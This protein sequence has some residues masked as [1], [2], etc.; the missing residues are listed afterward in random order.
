MIFSPVRSPIRSAIGS[1]VGLLKTSALVFPLDQAGAM[2]AAAYGVTRL[3]SAYSGPAIRVFR[4]S[5]SA[6]LDIGFSGQRLDAAALSTFL[7]SQVGKIVTFYDHSGNGGHI[8]QATDAIRAQISVGL[9]M[10]GGPCVAFNGVGEYALPAAISMDRRSSEVIAVA[11]FPIAKEQNGLFEIGAVANGNSNIFTQSSG[12]LQW[13]PNGSATAFK[14]QSAPR[15]YNQYGSASTSYFEQDGESTTAA[16]AT[17]VVSTG[18]HL[19]RLVSA[20][21]TAKMLFGFIAF[22]ARN[23]SAGER[24]AA[25]TAADLVFGCVS[26]G[27]LLAVQGDSIT[28]SSTAGTLRNGWIH[29]MIPSLATKPR[30]FNF[31]GGGEQLV[32][33]LV[34]GTSD[35]TT[36]EL[37]VLSRYSSGKRVVLVFKGTN[38]MGVANRTGAQVYADLQTYCGSI[39]ANGGKVI[40]CTLLPRTSYGLSNTTEFAA[41]NT[42][43]RTNWATFADGFVDFNQHPV[44]GAGGAPADSTLYLDGLHPTMYGNSLLAS[45]SAAEVNRV[46][47]L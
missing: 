12:A 17:S 42:S 29:Q 15:W 45:Y 33:D 43:V 3:S 40:V 10:A 14:V 16:A 47:A 44:M 21:Y 35:M 2:P 31:A 7:G 36:E 34:G 24:A 46:L 28:A 38:D 5:D 9:T 1:P 19:G 32:N 27:G 26:T 22:Y 20:G 41:F 8:T 23:L 30:I 18:G 4:P 39:R 13:R 25:K 6:E 11:E 37:A